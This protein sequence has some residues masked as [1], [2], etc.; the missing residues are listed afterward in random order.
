MPLRKV[1]KKSDDDVDSIDPPEEESPVEPGMLLESK[2]LY[3]SD[4][5]QDWAVWAPDDIGLDAKETDASAR[6]ALIVKRDKIQE[7]DG[8]SG[9]K[10]HSIQVQSPLIK[11]LLGPV[12][13]NYPG[14]KTSL[15]KLKFSAPF[16]EF[17]YRWQEFLQASKDSQ[18]DETQ[19]AHFK[20]LFDIISAEIRPHIE[21]VKDLLLNDVINHGFLWA[22]FEPGMEVYSLVDGQHGLY[23]LTSGN[24]VELP[25]GTKAFHL[26]CQFVDTD[27][28]NFGYNSATLAIGQF[29][30]VMPIVDLTVLPAHIKPEIE[31]IRAQ[32][33]Q[34]G[35]K[36]ESLNGC[37]YK[38][39]TGDYISA[40]AS[41]GRS[42][43]ATVRLALSTPLSVLIETLAPKWPYHGRRFHVH[44]I[45]Q[46]C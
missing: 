37:H 9:L 24:Y 17:F 44:S 16:R 25:D 21:E 6:F 32:L 35:N 19:A 22:L 23:R 42:R 8:S 46:G 34:R 28:V 3:R 29:A 15:K 33:V 11:T 13:T 14:I 27:G 40:N 31:S 36:F 43:K 7:D 41:W 5:R 38:A 12:F 10:L 18:H 26:S 2:D 30:D 39:Y 4:P 1:T 20:L 45:Q